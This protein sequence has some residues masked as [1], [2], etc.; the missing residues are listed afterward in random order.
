MYKYDNTTNRFP[1]NLSSYH[2]GKLTLLRNTMDFTL[3]SREIAED[4]LGSFQLLDM[5]ITEL[6]SHM[7]C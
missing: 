6:K 4:Q 3:F 2:D 1:S 5:I 7:T